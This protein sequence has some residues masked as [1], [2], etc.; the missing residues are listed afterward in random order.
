MSI[1]ALLA[2]LARSNF[3]HGSPNGASLRSDSGRLMYMVWPMKTMRISPAPCGSVKRMRPLRPL[4]SMNPSPRIGRPSTVMA[5]LSFA[6][7]AAA[8]LSAA[9]AT[10]G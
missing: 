2:T 9:C 10:R 4:L 7:P 8:V 5:R 3:I 6:P 1:P